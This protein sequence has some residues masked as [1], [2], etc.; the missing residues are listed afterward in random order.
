[1]LLF[2]DAGLDIEVVEESPFEEE[3]QT[4]N[5]DDVVLIEKNNEHEPNKASEKTKQW[6]FYK[7]RLSGNIYRK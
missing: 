2:Q 5:C 4:T 7:L 3:Q 6:K 1:M